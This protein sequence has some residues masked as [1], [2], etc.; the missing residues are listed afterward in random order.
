MYFVANHHTFLLLVRNLMDRLVL[1]DLLCFTEALM[2][3]FDMQIERIN[4]K[5]LEYQEEISYYENIIANNLLDTFIV[6][7]ND[8]GINQNIDRIKLAHDIIEDLKE[9]KYKIQYICSKYSRDRDF[10]AFN[11][12]KKMLAEQKALMNN[13]IDMLLY[14]K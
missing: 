14:F 8:Y 11:N 4:I 9:E 5:V 12:T 13:A 1:D 10:M 6:S 7:A 2:L 3:Y